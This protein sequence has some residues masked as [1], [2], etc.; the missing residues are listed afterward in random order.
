MIWSMHAKVYCGH[1]SCDSCKRTVYT[2]KN[3]P[4]F[5]VLKKRFLKMPDC[6]LSGPSSCI[7]IQMEGGNFTSSCLVIHRLPE[8]CIDT[9]VLFQALSNSV[10][11][12]AER[13]CSSSH[14]TLGN[15]ILGTK[16]LWIIETKFYC[17]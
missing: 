7:G 10:K 9:F 2:E 3:S 1:H 14:R 8:S 17:K 15:F 11:W 13:F 16:T 4:Y 12:F 6:L 5:I